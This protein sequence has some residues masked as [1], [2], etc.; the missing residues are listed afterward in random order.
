MSNATIYF[1]PTKKIPVRDPVIVPSQQYSMSITLTSFDQSDETGKSEIKSKSGILSS[2]LYYDTS[3]YSC[4]TAV[5]G[6]SGE[7]ET[8]IM[9]MFFAS[10]M[11]G[12]KFDISNLDAGGNYI[13]VQMSSRRSRSRRAD[14]DVGKFIYSFSIREAI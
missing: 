14:V 12:E 2:S 8:D 7:P 9:E 1:Y 5:S 10:T 11:N 13:E 3:N 6:E 4:T